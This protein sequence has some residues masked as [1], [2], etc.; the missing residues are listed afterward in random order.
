M[1]VDNDPV[2]TRVSAAS[3]PRKPAHQDSV[4]GSKEKH[5][6]LYF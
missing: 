4:L 1:C 5:K 3:I 6:L 2:H